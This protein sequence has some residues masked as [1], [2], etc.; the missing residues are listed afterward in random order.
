LALTV[1]GKRYLIDP[2]LSPKGSFD[3]VPHTANT[4]RN[5]LV[6][7]PLN[8]QELA[9][10]ITT[11]DAV[12]LTHIHPDHWDMVAQQ[13][14]RKDVPLFCQPTDTE[15]IKQGGFINVSP[16][17]DEIIGDQITIHRTGGQ[18]GTG[19]EGEKMGIVSGYVLIHG[20]H[21]IYIAGDT[22]WCDAVATAIGQFKP[23]H[24]ILN[25]GAARFLSGNP[26]VMDIE[27]VLTVCR[28]ADKAKIYVVHLE[29]VNHSTESRQEI[30]AALEI[31]GFSDRAY[32]PNDGELMEL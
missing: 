9:S 30:K 27:D 10:L 11:T 29:A 26:I 13:M 7:L 8:P 19:A 2:M 23:T 16:V 21:R 12:L 22:I 15:A 31:N 3:A 25:G 1:E 32:V 18:H 4:L 20:Q 17:N 5:P 24:I 6:D 14:L 28:T